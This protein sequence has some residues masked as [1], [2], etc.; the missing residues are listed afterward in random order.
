MG[1]DSVAQALRPCPHVTDEL[2]HVRRRAV[3]GEAPLHSGT[4]R[5]GD[6][7]VVSGTGGGA[8]LSVQPLV[9]CDVARQMCPQGRYLVIGYRHGTSL[10]SFAALQVSFA[11]TP[12]SL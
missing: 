7:R 5:G 8:E 6:Q 12:D 4:E 3:L 10:P 2:H 1:V 11:N 9:L